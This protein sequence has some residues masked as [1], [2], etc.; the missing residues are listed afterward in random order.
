[1]AD[2]TFKNI[3][4]IKIGDKVIGFKKTGKQKKCFVYSTVKK[5]FE[6][7]VSMIEVNMKS[8]RSIVCDINHD[9]YTGRSKDKYMYSQA[10][11]GKP[12]MYAV[13]PI[14][15]LKHSKDYMKGYIRGLIDGDGS[16]VNKVY[17][18]LKYDRHAKVVRVA[19]KDMEPLDRM[20]KFCNI[21]NITPRVGK[22]MYIYNNEQRTIPCIRLYGDKGLSLAL[23]SHINSNAYWKGWLA[24]IFDAEGSTYAVLRISQHKNIHPKIYNLINRTLHNFSFKTAEEPKGIRL[25]GGRK[26]IMRFYSLVQP[27]LWRKVKKVIIENVL[28][29]EHDDVI[30]IKQ[31]GK[32]KI[33]VL[34]TSTCNHVSNGYLSKN[35]NQIKLT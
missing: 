16:V 12:L 14:E 7:N 20:K 15:K 21:L 29:Y 3:E 24:G 19:M 26:E 25:L 8:G 22:S 28:K 13:V 35:L 32:R 6:E 2:G 18:D 10:R 31:I 17:H 23:S 27:T 1:M 34:N 33:H 4:D 30:S 9:W 11:V 5:T